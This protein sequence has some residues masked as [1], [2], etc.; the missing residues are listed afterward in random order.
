MGKVFATGVVILVVLVF[1]ACFYC[2]ASLRFRI[3]YHANLWCSTESRSGRGSTLDATRVIHQTLVELLPAMGSFLDAPCGDFNWMRGVREEVAGFDSKYTGLD[4]VPSL[5][6]A[7]SREFPTVRFV[8]GKLEAWT[9]AYDLVL[10]R[11]LLQHLS[12]PKQLELLR[13]LRRHGNSFLL[14]N[15]EPD[16]TRNTWVHSDPAPDWVPLNLLLHPFGLQPMRVFESDGVDKHYG[17]FDLQSE[18]QRV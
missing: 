16:V 3:I 13:V 1:L 12:T 11:D 14:I 18:H 9:S 7:N 17:L 6:R 4:I 15:Y 8:H 10:V 5:I 2:P